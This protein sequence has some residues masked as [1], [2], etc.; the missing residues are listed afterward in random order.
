MHHTA[1]DINAASTVSLELMVMDKP[2]EI[3]D[4]EPL[5]RKLSD[6]SSFSGHVDYEHYRPVVAGGGIMLA[7]ALDK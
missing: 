3:L 1:L 7:R 5:E 6:W 4:F 2:T